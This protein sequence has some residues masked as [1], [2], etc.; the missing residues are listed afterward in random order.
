MG[1]NIIKNINKNHILNMQLVTNFT[2]TTNRFQI[3]FI[4]IIKETKISQNIKKTCK[5][6]LINLEKIKEKKN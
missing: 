2:K 6:C 3:N 1:T 5:K 4:K